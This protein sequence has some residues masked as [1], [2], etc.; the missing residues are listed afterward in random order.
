MD[1]N[2]DLLFAPNLPVVQ[3]L[4]MC[5]VWK[6]DPCLSDHDLVDDILYSLAVTG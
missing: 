6:G 5:C 4:A 1:G 3:S 2:S